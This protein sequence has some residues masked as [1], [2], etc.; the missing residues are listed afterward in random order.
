MVTAVQQ[1]KDQALLCKAACSTTTCQQAEFRKPAATDQQQVG[2][3]QG[4][5]RSTLHVPAL[6]LG[7]ICFVKYLAEFV[8]QVR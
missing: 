4:H 7:G 8:L 5:Q 3:L 2:R 6:K 1:E